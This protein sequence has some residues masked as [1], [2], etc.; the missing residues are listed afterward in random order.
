ML[1]EKQETAVESQKLKG[2]I[3]L[4]KKELMEMKK[5]KL[6]SEESRLQRLIDRRGFDEDKVEVLCKAYEIYEDM[7]RKGRDDLDEAKKNIENAKRELRNSEK[8]SV[9]ERANLEDVQE[10]CKVCQE[11]GELRVEN[12]QEQQFVAKVEVPHRAATR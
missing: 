1:V 4:L 8:H 5:Y 2:E 12:R 6:R 11:I 3:E 9:K 7:S 10:I